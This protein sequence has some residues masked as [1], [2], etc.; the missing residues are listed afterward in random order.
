MCAI[1]S[2]RVIL[3]K[4]LYE[5]STVWIKIPCKCDYC[6]KEF[7]RS[8]RNIKVGR[9][10]IEKESCNSKECTKAKRSESNLLKYGVENSGGTKESQEKAKKTWKEKYGVDN[11][12]QSEEIKEKI[13]NTCLE[14]YGKTSFLGTEECRKKLSEYSKD[15]Y[16]VENIAQAEEIKDKI[17][18]TCAEKYG[19]DH[20]RK[21][22]KHME[23]FSKKFFKKHGVY[24]PSQMDDHLKKRKKT[25]LEKYGTDHPVKNLDIQNKI[26][27]T[28]LEKYGKYPVNC[29]G[30]TENEIK[31]FISQIGFDCAS[32]RI[33]LEGKEIDIFIPK[34][35]LG[36]E[37]CGLYWHNEMSPCPREKNYHYEKYTALYKQGIR[38]ITLFEDEWLNKKDI[39]KSILSSIVG[40]YKKRI[41]ARKTTIEKV[42]KNIAKNF[43]DENHL[44][45]KTNFISAYGLFYQKELVAIGTYGHHHRK[46]NKEIV[47]SR[48]CTKKD[49]QIVGG[50]SKL[51]KFIK[52]QFPS[53]TLITTWSDNRWSQGD[54][55]KNLKFHLD[56][57]LP[58]D[59]SYYQYGSLG[60]RKSKQ[61]MKK[62]NIGCP[63]H[64]TEK[65]WCLNNGYVRIWDCGKKRWIFYT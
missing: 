5:N 33:L 41:Y 14:K 57:E 42:E 49:I 43:L 34:K 16:G 28:C 44:Q 52:T 54:I 3:D 22:E 31:E 65:N 18:Q 58:P 8:K 24:Y 36:I 26:R 62:S 50:I 2:I 64:I 13:K 27:E 12:S 51:F 15:K 25:C 35:K 29:F 21:Y 40:K 23:E 53:G 20:P 38:L 32:D 10:T 55:Y 61:S 1:R 60:I 7:T 45:G 11:V 30:K 63:K 4:E 6:G 37:F 47:I 39:C 46:K 17:R 9:T 19:V 56:K 48:F 59:Y